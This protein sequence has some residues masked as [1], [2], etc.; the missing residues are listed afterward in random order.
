[1]LDDTLSRLA[2]IPAR[3]LIVYAPDDAA[4]EFAALAKGNFGLVPQGGGDLGDRLARFFA[5]HD[6]CRTIA[7]GSDSPTLP[8]AFL[9][10]AFEELKKA[11]VVLGPATDG[12][13]YLIG[14]RRC[15]PALFTGIEWGGSAVLR[16]T[17]ERLGA[18]TLAL[19]PPWYDIDTLDDWHMLAG[20]VAAMRRAGL[21]PGIPRTKAL[22]C[23]TRSGLT[24]A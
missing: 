19:L 20:H 8:L 21:D 1:L 22:L 12:G 6:G 10:Q 24:Q 5:A 9:E 3:R 13:Y 7:V 14:C 15:T 16:Q 2:A 17:V 4:A 23:S 18:H 11:D